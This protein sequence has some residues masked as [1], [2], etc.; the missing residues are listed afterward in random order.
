MTLTREERK[1]TGRLRGHRIMPA[2]AAWVTPQQAPARQVAACHRPMLLQRLQGI[3]RTR[4]CEAASRAQPGAQEKTVSAHQ[5]HQAAKKDSTS[6]TDHALPLRGPLA[7]TAKT[8]RISARTSCLSTSDAALRNS[9]F[10]KG[11]FR[12]NTQLHTGCS[13][14]IQVACSSAD[15]CKRQSSLAWC[16]IK[17]RVTERRA[18]FL[19]MTKPKRHTRR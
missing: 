15:A 18:I 1:Q 4:R 13:S 17:E 10:G 8:S 19:G 9:A 6:R 11:A 5:A 14:L 2:Q 7:Q 12:R 16:L 3:Q